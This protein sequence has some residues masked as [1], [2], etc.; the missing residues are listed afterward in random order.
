MKRW[1]MLLCAMASQACATGVE[2]SPPDWREF[3]AATIDASRKDADAGAPRADATAGRTFDLC[4][5]QPKPGYDPSGLATCC[6][7][8]AAHCVPASDVDP[9]LSKQLRAC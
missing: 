6:T 9:A 8:G 4:A 5:M 1:V 2:M 3:D 7:T